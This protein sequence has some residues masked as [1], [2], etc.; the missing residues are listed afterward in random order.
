MKI[1]KKVNAG[2]TMV[3]AMESGKPEEAEAAWN[4]AFEAIAQSIRADFDEL[5]GVTDA[6]ALAA[7]GYRQLT[8]P[9]E[10]F[11]EA[12]CNAAKAGSSV[13]AKQAFL[14][15][16]G[17]DADE[18]L[19]PVTIIEDVF[20]DLEQE[21]ELLQVINFT[22]TGY[23]TKWIRNTHEAAKAVWGKV[24]DAVKKEIESGLET[25]KLE[26][27]K[28]SAFL[29]IP[30]DIID[31]GYTF[32][33][34]YARACLKE[35]IADGLEAAIISGTGV[36]MPV[37]LDRDVHKGVSISSTDG[38]PKKEAV[39]V[40]SFDAVE[41]YGLVAKLSKTEKGKSRKVPVVVI[42]CN[43]TD[44]LTKV[45]PASTLL[46]QLGY[47]NNVFPYATKP[48]VSNEMDDGE[49]VMFVE[50][51][52]SFCV[53]GKRNGTI[54]VDDSFKFLDDARTFKI[55]QHGDGIADDDTAALLLDI[56]E[57][58]ALVPEVKVAGALASDADKGDGAD[59]DKSGGSGADKG[60]DTPT[61]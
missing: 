47:V 52:Y 1:N 51:C 12:L 18:D 23:A 24:T 39:K 25:M 9:E 22:Y 57:L 30:L 43:Q 10:R 29:I 40:K 38:Y 21:H 5:E 13:E 37:G 48:V 28:L 6:Q 26:Q 59:D 45:A 53:G 42:V 15:I 60:G 19:M 35:A 31:M 14:D 32:I 55:I 11:Y 44:Y 50:G 36:D 4:E 33:D 58:Q 7:R 8:K 34:A 20:K 49:A 3:K 16:T 2:A 41:F 27:N 54:D 17:D 56:S 61:V 46:T